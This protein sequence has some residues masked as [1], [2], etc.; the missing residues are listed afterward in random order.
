MIKKLLAVLF[1]CLFLILPKTT[2]AEGEFSTSYVVNYDIGQSGITT[3]TEKISLKNLTDKYYASSFSLA[4]GATKISDVAAFDPGGALDATLSQEGTKS[5]I[6]VKF[7]TQ[8]TGKDKVYSFTLRFDS[9]D[10]A[11]KQG[12]IWQVSVP[13]ISSSSDVDN[14]D[15]TLSVPVEFGD[16]TSILPNPTSTSE[17]EGKINLNFNKNQLL[18]SGILANFGTSQLFDFKLKY[19]L[20]N[21]NILPTMAKLPLPPDTEY[22]QVQINN[23]SPSPDNVVIDQDGNY[24]A[25]FKV[26]RKSSLDVEVNGLSKLFINSRFSTPVALSKNSQ[27]LYTSPQRYWEKDNPLIEA[28]LSEI[29]KQGE[30]SSNFEKAKLINQYVVDTLK[31]D[32][33]KLSN[34]DF[35][36]LGGLTVLNNPDN[37]LCSEFTDLFIALARAAGVPARELDGYAYTS[38]KDLRP[39]SLNGTVLHAWPEYFDPKLGWVMID[40][41]WQNTTGGV[42]YFSKFDLDHFVL[43]IRGSSSTEPLTASDVAVTFSDARFNP[44]PDLSINLAGNNEVLAGFPA[45]LNINLINRGSGLQGNS[46]LLVRVSRIDIPQGNSFNLPLIPPYGQLNYKVD[47]RT[48]SLLQSFD[49]SIYVSAGDKQ[50]VQQIRVKPFFAFSFFPL[51]VVVIIGAMV[52]IYLVVLTHHLRRHRLKV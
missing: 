43:G 50:V 14:Y 21:D 3:V 47:L 19:H 45:K 23:I 42:D 5:R 48:H 29:F 2:F 28:K 32:D 24:I 6:T 39:L 11:Q 49:D 1:F 38:N 12:K 31:Y 37:A 20:T 15:L 17:S 44:H 46:S 27:S 51:I 13:K 4:I 10:F 40:P 34:N 22:Q 26:D 30:P 35:S 52:A 16:P 9:Q 33:N 41:T 7:N 36:R 8:V 18:D 25:Y